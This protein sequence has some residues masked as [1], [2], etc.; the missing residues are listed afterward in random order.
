MQ[1]MKALICWRLLM[2]TKHKIAVIA[3]KL[4]L[5]LCAFFSIKAHA[6]N[7]QDLWFNEAESGWGVNIAQQDQ[8]LFGT[9]FIYDSNNQPSWVAMSDGARVVG[10]AVP[11]YKGAIIKTTGDTLAVVIFRAT[12]ISSFL[13]YISKNVFF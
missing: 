6:V 10:A 8:T 9:W 13:S 7:Y 2:Q 11:T 4:L 5:A 1:A 12:H 3:A